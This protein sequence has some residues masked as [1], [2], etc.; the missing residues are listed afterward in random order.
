MKQSCFLFLCNIFDRG[1]VRHDHVRILNK[2]PIQGK[3]AAEHTARR[4]KTIQTMMYDGPDIR[5]REFSTGHPEPGY[6][7]E[8]FFRLRQLFDRLVPAAPCAL[9]AIFRLFQMNNKVPLFDLY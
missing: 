3:V 7:A 6:F 5:I 8:K 2:Q 9:S 1:L 4:S